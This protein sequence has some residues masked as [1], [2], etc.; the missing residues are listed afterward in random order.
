MST[1][2]IEKLELLEWMA[3]LQDEEIISKLKQWK[4]NHQRVSLDQY[5]L[6]I[7]EADA[8]IDRGEFYTQDEV[9]QRAKS[10]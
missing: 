10:W 6:E 2:Q 5:N 3:S 4:E 1:T 8:A 9:E 7:E